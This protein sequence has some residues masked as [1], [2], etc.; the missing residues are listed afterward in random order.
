VGGGSPAPFG[1]TGELHDGDLV[2]LRARWYHPSTGTFTAR[3]PF[4]GFDTLPYSLHPYQYAYSNPVLWTDPSGRNP[5]CLAGAAVPGPGWVAGAACAVVSIGAT[6]LAGVAGWLIGDVAGRTI[7][8]ARETTERIDAGAAPAPPRHTGNHTPAPVTPPS[9]PHPVTQDVPRG[10]NIQGTPWEMD[11][12]LVCTQEGFPMPEADDF[13]VTIFPAPQ[14]GGVEIYTA[15]MSDILSRNMRAA[16]IPEPP[17]TAAHHIVAWNDSRAAGSRAI[18]I[19][20]NIGINDAENG[21]YLPISRTKGHVTVG[22]VWH[23]NIHTNRYHAEVERRLSSAAPGTVRAE[24][25]QIAQ[26]ILQ[27]LFP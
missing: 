11:D 1:F 4:A 24:L 13:K 25:Q 10:G 14:E 21:V 15:S 9:P 22:N 16:G 7:R 20:E 6:I 23:A 5:V 2:H 26:E 27:G 3:D 12:S 17:G 8:D 18:L 19:G